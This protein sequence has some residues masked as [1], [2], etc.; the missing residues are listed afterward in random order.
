MREQDP[1]AGTAI[2]LPIGVLVMA[3]GG[4]NSLDEIPGYL[5]DI[6]GGRPTTPA[7][8]EEITHNY[9]AIGGR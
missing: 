4:P 7:V 3:Y 6:R 8:L 2:N 1:E 5:A 9:R